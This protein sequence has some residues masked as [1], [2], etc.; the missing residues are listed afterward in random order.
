MKNYAKNLFDVGC[1]HQRLGES[2]VSPRPILRIMPNNQLESCARAIATMTFVAA[3]ATP[4][5]LTDQRAGATGG[6]NSLAARVG[7]VAPNKADSQASLNH[8]C[9]RCHPAF[10]NGA[11]EVDMHVDG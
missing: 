2:Y 11:N 6:G 5:S 4:L 7:D 9:I 10:T 8:L 1:L 3:A